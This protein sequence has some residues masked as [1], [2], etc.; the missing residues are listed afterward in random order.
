MLGSL[1]FILTTGT[2]R[3]E[4]LSIF[5]MCVCVCPSCVMKTN[6]F[7]E[8]SYRRAVRACVRTYVAVESDGCLKQSW[9]EGAA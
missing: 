4:D 3:E 2:R 9:T 7:I 5:S 6:C 1:K 8:S